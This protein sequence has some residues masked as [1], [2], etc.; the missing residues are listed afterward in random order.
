MTLNL[1]IFILPKISSFEILNRMDDFC[2]REFTKCD[3]TFIVQQKFYFLIIF[4][5]AAAL[6]SFT[7]V[8]MRRLL[9]PGLT[10]KIPN[11]FM[12]L[13]AKNNV[14]NVH[15]CIFRFMTLEAW[16]SWRFSVNNDFKA[17]LQGKNLV[18]SCTGQFCDFGLFGI[19]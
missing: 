1:N 15:M 3:R 13:I 4:S 12:F 16:F 19:S 10:T 6:K 8:Y 5:L 17:R 14:P 9:M 7:F 2:K 18:F 11:V